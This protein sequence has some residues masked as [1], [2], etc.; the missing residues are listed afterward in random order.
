V[1]VGP[2]TVIETEREKETG[3]EKEE[4]EE[5]MWAET[6]VQDPPLAATREV[7]LEL[8]QDPRGESLKY[9]E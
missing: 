6:M 7:C 1:T 3:R 9:V 5:T 8:I 2:I 4:G